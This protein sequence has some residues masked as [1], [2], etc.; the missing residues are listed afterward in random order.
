MARFVA[1]SEAVLLINNAGT[2]GPVGLL[3]QHDPAGIAAAVSLNLAAPLMLADALRRTYAGEVR[4]CH[5]SSG[6][7]REGGSGGDAA[8]PGAQDALGCGPDGLHARTRRTAL[9]GR[10]VDLAS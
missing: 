1:G 10:G 9:L 2:L 8:V 5:L 7:A 4:I 6:A 3:G